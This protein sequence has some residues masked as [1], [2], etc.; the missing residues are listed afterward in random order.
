MQGFG[1]LGWW[2]AVKTLSR[3]QEEALAV[4]KRCSFG[5]PDLF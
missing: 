5:F 4:E 1:Y 3:K 2:G